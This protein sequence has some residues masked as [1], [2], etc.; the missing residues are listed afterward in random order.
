MCLRADARVWRDARPHDAVL[1][2][3]AI[4]YGTLRASRPL[5]ECPMCARSPGW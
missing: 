1:A 4:V 3:R 5:L 2:R